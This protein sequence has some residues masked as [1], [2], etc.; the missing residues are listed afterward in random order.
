MDVKT[1][2]DNVG[3]D[4]TGWKAKL[5]DVIRKTQTLDKVAKDEVAPLVRELNELVDDLDTR[6][7]IL[8]RECPARWDTEKAEIQEKMAQVNTKW[9]DAWGTMDVW[10][11][12]LRMPK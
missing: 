1:F 11:M 12:G 4:L 3:T 9:K 5:Y 7:E 8:D 2:C 10:N 6:I